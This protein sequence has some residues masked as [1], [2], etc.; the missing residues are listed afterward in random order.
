MLRL[1]IAVACCGGQV[2]PA[3][4]HVESSQIRYWTCVSCIGR[5]ILTHCTTREVL[6][7]SFNKCYIGLFYPPSKCDIHGGKSQTLRFFTALQCSTAHRALEPGEDLTF[8]SSLPWDLGE[9]T[10]IWQLPVYRGDGNV[11]TEV[12]GGWKCGV[13][14][15]PERALSPF[16]SEEVQVA[17]ASGGGVM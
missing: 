2:L 11:V 14:R 1:L 10:F 9:L 4:W 12:C 5:W 8:A 7:V 13:L 17:K 6:K 3:P 15:C 16:W